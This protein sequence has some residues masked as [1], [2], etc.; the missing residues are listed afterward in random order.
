MPRSPGP[1]SYVVL[2]PLK[3]PGRGK[4]RLG[5]LPR[6]VL[7]AAFATDT[8]MACLASPSVAQVLVVTDDASF[9]RTLT[10]LGCEAMPDGVSGDLNASLVLAAMEAERRWPGLVPVAICADL[11]CLHA[12][13]LE[14]AL[15]QKPGWPR[16]VADA[17]GHGTTLYTAPLDEFAP[18]FGRRSAA[19]HADAGAWPVE[20]ELAG[21]RHDVD[22]VTDLEHAVRLGLG[23]HSASAVSALPPTLPQTQ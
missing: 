16:F 7:A 9:A 2:L 5:D 8:A 18:R 10:T 12:E 22:D 14:A 3:P 15:A 1:V 20:G 23:R 4:S 13:D 21:L 11:P 17:S 19:Q 6:D